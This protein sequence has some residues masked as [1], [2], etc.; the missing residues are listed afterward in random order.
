MPTL[1]LRAA[2]VLGVTHAARPHLNRFSGTPKTD[3]F[4][5]AADGGLPISRTRA[6]ESRI[7]CCDLCGF[8]KSVREALPRRMV[9][10]QL[11]SID[12]SSIAIMNPGSRCSEETNDAAFC[13]NRHRAVPRRRHG[14][15]RRGSSP[16]R[17][18]ARCHRVRR[19]GRKDAKRCPSTTVGAHVSIDFT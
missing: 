10:D 11:R 13:S 3:R 4:M 9:F 2:G 15:L 7:A 16:L 17:C 8:G 1:T 12:T 19:G 14:S 5:G 6:V 18:P